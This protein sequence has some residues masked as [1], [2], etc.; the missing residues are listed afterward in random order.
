MG[1]SAPAE[2]GTAQTAMC[3][4]VASSGHTNSHSRASFPQLAGDQVGTPQHCSPTPET[5]NAALHCRA[6]TP[7]CSFLKNTPRV[8]A[9]HESHLSS[10]RSIHS[11]GRKC[12]LSPQRR[13]ERTG[14]PVWRSRNIGSI[15]SDIPV[16][17]PPCDA[18][19]YISSSSNS[20]HSVSTTGKSKT[21][22]SGTRTV[23]VI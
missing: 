6:P 22:N 16:P 1:T 17:S 9:M 8:S 7:S 13:E 23:E 12:D 4:S 10:H 18:G 2:P 21:Q 20:S 19:G 11:S 15:T 3:N 14:V 5:Y